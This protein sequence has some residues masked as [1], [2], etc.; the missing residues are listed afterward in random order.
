MRRRR[1]RPAAPK[2]D[3]PR[4]KLDFDVVTCCADVAHEESGEFNDSDGEL[5]DAARPEESRGACGKDEQPSQVT[6]TSMRQVAFLDM[7][8]PLCSG[9]LEKERRIV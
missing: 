3:Q 7:P 1:G 5:E 9:R 6:Q 8:L 4:R 2:D